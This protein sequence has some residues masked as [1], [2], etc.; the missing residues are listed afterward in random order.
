MLDQNTD[1]MWYVIGALVVGAGIILLANKTMPEVF[2]NITKTFKDTTDS[3]TSAIADMTIYQATDGINRVDKYTSNKA[4]YWRNGEEDDSDPYW[5]E[6]DVLVDF[7]AVK[8]GEKYKV[9]IDPLDPSVYTNTFRGGYYYNK[10]K[11][12]IG[13]YYMQGINKVIVPNA[14]ASYNFPELPNNV[15]D[16]T[17]AYVRFVFDGLL[18]DIDLDVNDLDI[19]VEKYTDQ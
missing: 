14:N 6:G 3:A 15:K 5:Y 18:K 19:H 1:R 7:I 17:P 8:P 10:D 9:W 11:E 12:Y 4:I 2:A 16:R 13:S